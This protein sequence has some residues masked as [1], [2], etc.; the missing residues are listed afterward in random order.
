MCEVGRQEPCK[1]EAFTLCLEAIRDKASYHPEHT[2]YSQAMCVC[3]E[4]SQLEACLD[5]TAQ[6]E[7]DLGKNRWERTSWKGNLEA[8][9]LLLL[10]RS[11]AQSC[12][13]LV[14]PWT[15]T[16]QAP[17]RMGFPRQEYW[18]GLLFP[19]PGDPPDPGSN[20]SF[21]C[22]QADSLPS[23]PLGKPPNQLYSDKN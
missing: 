12:P 8:E 20:Q 7:Y 1:I 11:V 10:S 19:P 17:L 2:I 23:E 6:Q 5:I 18:S 16:C 3:K 4:K 13:I 14:T 9:L 21:L 22:L 15:V